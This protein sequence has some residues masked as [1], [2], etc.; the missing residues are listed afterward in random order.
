MIISHDG[1]FCYSKEG[2]GIILPGIDIPKQ[3]C[4]NIEG[5]IEEKYVSKN[6]QYLFVINCKRVFFSVKKKSD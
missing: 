3:L 6:I 2:S 4:Y 1:C 5:Q